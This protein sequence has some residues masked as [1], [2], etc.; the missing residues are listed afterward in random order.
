MEFFEDLIESE[1]N[2]SE[3]SEDNK[4]GDNNESEV[5]EDNEIDS[6][7]ADD[8]SDLSN[9]NSDIENDDIVT[10]DGSAPLNNIIGSSWFGRGLINVLKNQEELP[11]EEL[12]QEELT[13]EEFQVSYEPYI[14]KTGNTP[15]TS[16]LNLPIL[17]EINFE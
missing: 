5:S 15:E 6:E 8:L 7:I 10:F 14:E 17:A 16:I 9:E 1:D 3:V 4:G 11:Q 12:P 2:K 13:Q